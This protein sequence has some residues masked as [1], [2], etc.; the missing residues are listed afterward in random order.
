MKTRKN[1][2]EVKTLVV[3]STIDN[4]NSYDAY[5]G[6]INKAASGYAENYARSNKMKIVNCPGFDFGVRFLA[7]KLVKN[8][9]ISCEDM[10]NFLKTKSYEKNFMDT[11]NAWWND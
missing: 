7:D 5:I 11:R 4:S 6:S 3:K 2:K 10:I 1:S 8:N 9:I